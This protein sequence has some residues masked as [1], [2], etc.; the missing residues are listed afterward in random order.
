M[1]RRGLK[2]RRQLSIAILTVQHWRHIVH[3]KLLL[4]TLFAWL[5]MNVPIL[6]GPPSPERTEAM[7]NWIANEGPLTCSDIL[8]LIDWF[9]TSDREIQYHD[10]LEA[11][12]VESAPA[13]SRHELFDYFGLALYVANDYREY[14]EEL[15]TGLVPIPTFTPAAGILVAFSHVH[16]I[17]DGQLNH[18]HGAPTADSAINQHAEFMESHIHNTGATHVNRIF[19][20]RSTYIGILIGIALTLLTVLALKL[21]RP[22]STLDRA[23]L[24]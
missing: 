13:L 4:M 18:S 20:S 2:S 23:S 10:M 14:A 9:M 7:N 1:M 22:R 17:P 24:A 12:C 21:L 5:V 15:K 11:E 3:T 16:E 8:F 6:A 19:T